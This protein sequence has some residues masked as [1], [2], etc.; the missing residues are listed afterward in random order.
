MALVRCAVHRIP[1]HDDR[2]GGCPACQRERAGDDEG[3]AIRALAKA[4]KA[5]HGTRS[6]ATGTN[7]ASPADAS[8]GTKA[9]RSFNL[10]SLTNRPRALWAIVALVVIMG[11]TSVWLAQTPRLI[12]AP[13]PL[14]APDAARPLG[15]EPNN[16]I[17]LVFATLGVRQPKPHPGSPQLARYEYG[18]ELI[19]DALNDVVYAIHLGVSG[20]TWRGLQIG[21]SEQAA[22]G[23]LALLGTIQTPPPEPSQS[24]MV[25]KGYDAYPSTEQRPRRV[26]QVEVRPPNACFDVFVD[27]QPQVIGFLIDGRQRFAVVGREGAPVTWVVTRIRAIS[28]ALPGPG[29]GEI[30][31]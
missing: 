13:S 21:L 22:T 14:A 6:D 23:R 29:S 8:H 26:R 20:R 5:L 11:T 27:L 15:F 4:S 31:C 25:V 28:R 10:E 3:S 16:S 2:P 12:D 24:A 1:Y 17:D 30:V 7:G 19:V 9:E 18:S